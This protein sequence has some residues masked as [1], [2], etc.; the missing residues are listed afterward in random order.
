MKALCKTII[1]ALIP[2]NVIFVSAG[3]LVAK[4][5][6]GTLLSRIA[7]ERGDAIAREKGHMF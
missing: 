1:P 5:T 6:K 4:G 7:V 2:F 3:N